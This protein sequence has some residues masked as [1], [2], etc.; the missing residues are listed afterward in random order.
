MP[1]AFSRPF[2]LH[3]SLVGGLGSSISV[4]GLDPT[5]HCVVQALQIASGALEPAPERFSG[6]WNPS[7]NRPRNRLRNLPTQSSH[8]WEKADF[9]FTSFLV[10]A[11]VCFQLKTSGSTMGW[12]GASSLTRRRLGAV[13]HRSGSL[14]KQRLSNAVGI[15]FNLPSVE[16]GTWM[17]VQLSSA[18]SR[19]SSCEASVCP[20]TLSCRP[21]FWLPCNALQRLA[22]KGP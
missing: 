17:A 12:A 5:S 11:R 4:R 18:P 10:E 1:N 19:A 2:K 15:S 14:L 20:T 13:C 22:V 6:T 8:C 9:D 3:L 16:L 21:P 7:R